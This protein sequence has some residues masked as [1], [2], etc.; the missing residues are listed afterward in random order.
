MKGT[1]GRFLLILFLIAPGCEEGDAVHADLVAA[2]E[3][4]R[5][6]DLDQT[7]ER[8]Q[9]TE[10]RLD[11][12]AAPA[13]AAYRAFL[14]GLVAWERSLAFEAR[15]KTP[16]ADPTDHE[17]AVASTVDALA[18]WRKA[19]ATRGDWPSARRNVERALLRLDALRDRRAPSKKQPKP[20]PGDDPADPTQKPPQDRP[21]PPSGETGEGENPPPDQAEGKELDPKQVMA[22]LE[23]LK[24]KQQE[25]Q[26]L[27]RKARGKRGT[28]VERDW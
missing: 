6:G 14:A 22:L 18:A 16:Q 5:A 4:L 27:R 17:R 13:Q 21:P 20:S 19:C 1:A 23:R 3:A 12:E 8:L 26:E 10:G 15:S 25:K 11:A 7:E 9:A 28:D 24:E 2:H